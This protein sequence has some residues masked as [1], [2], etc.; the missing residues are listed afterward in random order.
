ME[1]VENDIKTGI[2]PQKRI[3][4][5]ILA[6]G[7][8]KRFGGGKCRAELKGKP[9]IAWVYEAISPFCAEIWLSWR[10]PPYEGPEL[11][12]SRIIYDEKPGAGPAV[13]LNSALKKKKEGH[14]LVLPCDQPLVRPKLLKKLIKT[15]QDEP[16]WETVVFRD[17]QRLLPF[18]GLYSKATTIE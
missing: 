12:F 18:P 3:I 1:S 9:L 13:A 14:L 11:P 2:K 7:L 10:R 5:L 15:A 8:A 4:G 16:F 6:G 17:D